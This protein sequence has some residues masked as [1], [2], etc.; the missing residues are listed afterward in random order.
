MYAQI[1]DF[2][3]FIEW[4]TAYSQNKTLYTNQQ[5]VDDHLTL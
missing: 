3:T 5:V 4:S 1:I 2:N